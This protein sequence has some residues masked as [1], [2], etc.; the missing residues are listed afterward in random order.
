MRVLRFVFVLLIALPA[1]ASTTANDDSCDIAVQPA[2]TLLLPYFEV[3]VTDAKFGVTTIFT[4]TNVSPQPQIANVTFWTDWGYPVLNFPLFLSGYD[5]EPINLF[6][7]LGRGVITGSAVTDPVPVNP[8]LGSQPAPNTANPNFAPGVAAHCTPQFLPGLIPPTILAN[9]RGYL[10]TGRGPDC[11]GP[12][13]GVHV[14][15]IGYITIDVVNDCVPQSPA[16]AGY[17][18]NTILFDNVLTGDYQ[19]IVPNGALRYA[20]GGP[21]VHIRAIPGGGAAGSAAAAVLP[22]TFYDRLT[23]GAPTR[24][25]DRRQ[26]LP[27]LFAARFIQGGTGGFNTSFRIWREPMTAAGAPCTKYIDNSGPQLAD[28]VRFD[29]HENSAINNGAIRILPP[30]PPP[31]PPVTS[32]FPS[33]SFVFPVLTTSFDV[34]GWMYLNLNNG[35]SAA[36]STARPSQNWVIV[37]MFAPPTFATE[38]PALILANGC[39]PARATG[40]QISP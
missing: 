3:D 19:V 31:G 24:S 8:T 13:G 6:D 30:P 34:G 40:A 20:A 18:T 4:V 16:S 15:L 1:A 11:T 22:Y 39:S 23:V 36:Y 38:E 12:V 10:T 37:T 29:E 28:V 21:M 17:F 32:T 25:Y 5:V 14:N 35:G 26:P 27:S 7:V 33:S 2:A 9:L